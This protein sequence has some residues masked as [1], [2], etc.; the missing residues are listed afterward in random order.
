MPL[1]E[2]MLP[3]EDEELQ[4]ILSGEIRPEV[5]E[6]RVPEQKKSTAI[7]GESLEEDDF[8]LPPSRSKVVGGLVV[9]LCI[10]G[11]AGAAQSEDA[12][13]KAKWAAEQKVLEGKARAE[14]QQKRR[15]DWKS[16]GANMHQLSWR[17]SEEEKVAR[18]RLPNCMI[19]ICDRRVTQV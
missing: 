18:E 11:A 7:L 10:L 9:L 15:P 6:P 3:G 5:V 19:L 2:T 8:K 12:D 17:R 16:A 1:A 14:T 13:A 4:K